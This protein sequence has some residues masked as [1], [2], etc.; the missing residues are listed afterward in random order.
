MPNII[1]F[2]LPKAQTSTAEVKNSGLQKDDRDL[3]Y[4]LGITMDTDPISE[5]RITNNAI[6][7]SAGKYAG[8]TLKRANTQIRGITAFTI[9]E[10]L[11]TIEDDAVLD[12]IEFASSD[13]NFGKLVD[14]KGSSVAVFRNC[15]FSKEV[16]GITDGTAVAV[17]AGCKAVFVGCVFRGGNVVDVPISNSAA[18]G[19]VQ[20]VGCYNKTGVAFG[21]T[22]TTT[23][24]IE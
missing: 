24:V 21:A 7:L 2:H 6:T 22:V 9:M 10:G 11:L 1:N 14:V 20:V 19:D 23:G 17:A 15:T 4:S 8:A 16:D 13:K 5:H 3:L 12:G 18:A